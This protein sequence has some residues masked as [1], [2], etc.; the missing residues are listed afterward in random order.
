MD[1]RA[2]CPSPVGCPLLAERAPPQ[3]GTLPRE[4]TSV[5]FSVLVFFSV[6]KG[7]LV[8]YGV[9]KGVLVLYSVP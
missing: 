7:V 8:L 6:F 1:G 5:F 9:F 2:D 4:P 3:V